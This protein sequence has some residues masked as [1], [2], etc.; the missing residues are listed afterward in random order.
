MGK[1]RQRVPETD[2]G[3]GRT[4]LR[5]Y[6]IPLFCILKNYSDGKFQVM[7]ISVQFFK[8]ESIEK[9]CTETMIV[10]FLFFRTRHTGKTTNN[11]PFT[12]T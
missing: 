11:P 12:I 2:V 1:A 10:S 8:K 5:L 7:C 4:T 6:L 9:S 3:H